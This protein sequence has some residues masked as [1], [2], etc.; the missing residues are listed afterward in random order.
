MQGGRMTEEIPM[1][2]VH[3]V[4]TMKLISFGHKIVAE[5]NYPGGIAGDVAKFLEF[6]QN[7]HKQIVDEAIIHP[8]ASKI[9]I[10]KDIINQRNGTNVTQNNSENGNQQKPN[11]TKAPTRGNHQANRKIRRAQK[12]S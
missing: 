10:L 6:L 3:K 5:T 11:P 9:Q 4:N 2:L 7:I 1:E 12:S 8:D